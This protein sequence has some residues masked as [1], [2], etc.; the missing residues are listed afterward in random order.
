MKKFFILAVTVFV[1]LLGHT[2]WAHEIAGEHIE[3]VAATIHVQPDSS[4]QVEERIVYN[5]AQNQRHGIFRDIPFVYQARGGNY[6]LRMRV[7]SVVDE[8]GAA[9]PFSATEVGEF[10]KIKIGDPDKTITGRHTYVIAYTVQGAINYFPDHDELYWNVTGHGVSVE[11]G[12]ATAK[13]FLPSLEATSTVQMACFA[14][15]PRATTTCASSA[16]VKATPATTA[17]LI[18]E[19]GELAPGE[20]LTVV[21]GWPKGFVEERNA[22]EFGEQGV[23]VPSRMANWL[24]ALPVLIFVGMFWLWRKFGR[25]PEG[26]GTIVAEFEPPD[27]LSP[28]EVGT[29]VDYTV[30]NKDVAAEIIYLA[31][32][33]YLRIE[34]VAGEGML[35][36]DDYILHRLKDADDTLTPWQK[37]LLKELFVGKHDGKVALSDLKDTFSDELTRVK[38]MIYD[39]LVKKH[40]FPR[41]PQRVKLY[42]FVIA[43]LVVVGGFMGGVFLGITWGSSV[44][45]VS[46]LLSGA[47]IFIFGWFMPARTL[48]G[49]LAKE[50]IVGLKRYLT[51]AEKDRLAFHNAPEKNPERFE[52]LLPYAMALGV[53]KAWAEQFK[54]LYSAPS[55]Y[56]D[57]QLAT[58]NAV[59]FASNLSSFTAQASS[60]LSSAPAAS[61]TSG[62]SSGGGFSGG[63][64]GGGGGGSW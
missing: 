36:A 59:L 63:G 57:P 12:H 24:A 35:K 26:R 19:D 54:D 55:W 25:D 23:S 39:A 4:M 7:L 13:I 16:L 5:F 30:H 60:A 18:F 58:F 6:T 38:D 56:S 29:I 14:G 1:L 32:K 33:G 46:F 27:D 2:A 20:G 51:V 61:G 11:T 31:T 17:H 47:I 42:Y 49:V 10:L 53:E 41:H 34:R 15:A 45:I 28:G 62:F 40:Y 37:Q 3:E 50:H 8:K 44:P 52:K 64:F 9:Y 22:A 21:V 43:V 48:K